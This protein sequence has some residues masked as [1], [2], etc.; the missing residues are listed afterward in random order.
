MKRTTFKILTLFVT[1]IAI[2][3]FVACEKEEAARLIN[4]DPQEISDIM[5]RPAPKMDV[6][7][8]DKKDGT[9]HVINISGNAWAAHAAHGDVRLDDQDDD[10]FVP[11]NECGF[12]NMGD[13]DDNNASISPGATEVCDEIDNN[14]D[15]NIDEGV[16]TTYYADA[17]NDGYGDAASSIEA[18]SAPQGFVEDNT[19][20]D[21]TDAAIN[22]AAEE[23]CGNGIDDNCDGNVDEDCSSGLEFTVDFGC[24]SCYTPCNAGTKLVHSEVLGSAVTW[25]QAVALCDGLDTETEDW[26]LVRSCELFPILDSYGPNP[27]WANADNTF[28]GH[29]GYWTESFVS[30]SFLNTPLAAAYP[31]AGGANVGITPKNSTSRAGQPLS[32]LCVLEE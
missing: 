26:R 18:C 11:D 9:W 14:C 2:V 15:G 19:D 4:E 22:P 27:P 1:L 16:T 30:S 5:A 10:G 32:C 8:Y 7:H 24:P 20:C 21:D 12:G 23:V 3:V 6:C 29:Y 17:D 25:D 28:D 13:C 31:A